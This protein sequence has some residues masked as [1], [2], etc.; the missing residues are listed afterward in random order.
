[1]F[2]DEKIAE[3]QKSSYLRKKYAENVDEE[4][5][6][7]PDKYEII[8]SQ[9]EITKAVNDGKLDLNTETYIF[10][11][12]SFLNEKVKVFIIRDFFDIYE[13]DDNIVYFIKNDG[14][15]ILIKNDSF[16]D[17]FKNL[18]SLMKYL[19]SYC[20]ENE[21]YMEFIKT[22]EESV[23]NQKRYIVSS[24]MPTRV[25]YIFQYTYYICCRDEII[26]ITLSCLDEQRNKWEKIMTAIASLI[27]IKEG[28]L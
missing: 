23:G 5:T 1:M 13:E 15:N 24:R 16:S 11:K 12:K 9:E 17:E 28:E 14:F 7:Q 25:G 27:E 6:E 18:E 4:E 10:E 8:L 3:L 19:T 2:L 26:A 20:K 21:I 22:E